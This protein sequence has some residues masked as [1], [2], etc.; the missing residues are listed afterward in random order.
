MSG[1]KGASLSFTLFI[2]IS[3]V[4]LGVSGI[5]WKI[6]PKSGEAGTSVDRGFTIAWY[7]LEAGDRIWYEYEAS[8]T[9]WFLITTDPLNREVEEKLNLSGTQ[10]SGLY[11]CLTN[12]RY[13]LWVNF[14]EIPQDG[15]ATIDYESYALDDS[16]VIV[17]AAKPI[18]SAI[19]TI[20]LVLLVY[21]SYRRSYRADSGTTSGESRSFWQYFASRIGNWIAVIAGAV[22]VTAASVIDSLN[23]T[24]DLAELMLSLLFYFGRFV[25]LI[26]VP[27]G[28]YITWS[29]YKARPLH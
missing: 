6:G 22:F 19:L 14:S 18:A 29:E 8:A 25:I 21:K 28:L 4:I 17:M 12:D 16:S 2:A 26:G 15:I 7:E 27:L 3:I 10:N 23:P 5:P 13:Y 24:A 20:L 11:E 9:C 1:G